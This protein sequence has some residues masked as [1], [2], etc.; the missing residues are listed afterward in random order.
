MIDGL[1]SICNLLRL[2][3]IKEKVYLK[4]VDK[5]ADPD[6][7]KAI[8]EFYT[9]I[10][11]Y[12]ARVVCHLS[13]NS[14]K[15]G[16]RG[17]L[18]LDDWKDLLEK[19]KTSDS[20]CDRYC[21]IFSEEK[22]RQFYAEESLHIEQS[23]DIQRRVFDVLEA[24]RALRQ[25]ERQH[26]KEAELLET[27]ASDY[28]SD[29]DSISRR[30][31]GTCEWFTK[32]KRF[33][34]WRNSK[35]SR[36]L[37]VSAGPGCGKSVL[38]R[39]L[40]DERKVCTNVMITTVCYFFFK[41]AQEQ[42]TRSAD[43][44]SAMLH[45]IYEKTAPTSQALASYKNYGNKLRDVFSELWQLLVESAK[46]QETG[47]IIC[48]LDAL[49]ECEEVSRNQLIDNLVDFFSGQRSDEK[50]KFRLKFLVTSRP[51]DNVEQ[52][53]QKLSN[54]ST[55]LRFDGDDKSQEISQEINL[56]ID[57]RIPDIAA[58]FSDDDRRRISDRLKEMNNRTYLWLFLTIDVIIRSR[59]NFRKVSSI[60]TLLSNLPSTVSDAYEKILT[61]SS[62]KNNAKILLQL[63]VAATRPL[64]LAEANIALTLA[65]QGKNCTPHNELDLWPSQTFKSTIQNM[66]GLFINVHDE[67][68]TL[69][70]QTA[71]EFLIRTTQSGIVPLN[72]W[73]GKWQGC[74]DIAT[75]H[76][77]ISKVCL[78]YLSLDEFASIS[79]YEDGYSETTNERYRFLD[80]AALNWV[81]HYTSQQ[82]E[83]AKE[84][85]KAA[86]NLCDTS[87]SQRSI[88]FRLYCRPKRINP[89]GW[90]SLEIASYLGLTHVAEEV[91]EGG[92]DLNFKS[93]G[94]YGSALH[95]AIGQGHDK[96]V[97]MLIEK[98][99][100][101]HTRANKLKPIR[102]QPLWVYHKRDIT[103]YG[104]DALQAASSLGHERIVQMLLE[105]GANFNDQSNG[106]TALHYASFISHERIIQMLI[107][108]GAD[109]DAR[110]RGRTALHCALIKGHEKVVP[111][112][113]ENGADVD[114]RS[115]RGT[116]LYDASR[117]GHEKV[118]QILIENGADVNARSD[119]VTSL[120]EA[121]SNGHEKVVQ[122]LIENG[123]DVNARSDG[124]TSL[125]G[126]SRHGC[127]KV[128]QIL[129]ENDANVDAQSDEGTP[130]HNASRYGY[131]KVVQI[132]IENGANVDAH[133][134]GGTPLHGALINS[135]E[136]MVRIL[137][138]MGAD[139]NARVILRSFLESPSYQTY[140]ERRLES[141]LKLLG[142]GSS[143]TAL[144]L[145]KILRRDRLAQILVENGA[146]TSETELQRRDSVSM[147]SNEEPAD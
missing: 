64:R 144:Q 113:I 75:A 52:K 6:F 97:H 70:H 56:V 98:G 145:A 14:I 117:Y 105:N 9:D 138:K 77:Q 30:V 133:S 1:T 67:K 39:F 101:V 141:E 124:G 137:I 15:R 5:P 32:D 2:Y 88:W 10:F 72:K 96:V 147:I 68:I 7:V 92:V 136:N 129:I 146:V 12:Q 31:P 103:K 18:K 28:R 140:D 118:V 132:L 84:L 35:F 51:Y 73:P 122:I 142:I 104:C 55:Y 82:S 90:A 42:R 27:L 38:S 89:D 26:D 21:A 115:D 143:I 22:E 112:L 58:D 111:I 116:P 120:Y 125:H 47:E 48:V 17:T 126:A 83:S 121:S 23:I 135:K 34:D 19:V 95:A 36:L 127:E 130:L 46:D 128:V 65:T 107:E 57:A 3:R 66:C 93:K 49:D 43:A 37:W 119:D 50:S 114:A 11:E 99:A 40:I 24:S 45:Q 79:Q 41:D 78:D 106:D 87:L 8:E 86:Q 131:E 109:V 25:H 60:E 71:R 4:N 81:A 100:D 76:S 123:A 54:V 110:N 69:I 13:R 94:Y 108:F 29:K 20:R 44:L 61:R 62:D 80:Y 16:F 85:Q 33:L 74:L 91:I 102:S 134:D 59:S 53:F 139:V 63:I